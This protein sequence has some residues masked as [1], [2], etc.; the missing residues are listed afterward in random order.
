MDTAPPSH[1]DQLM[2]NTGVGPILVNTA[3]EGFVCSKQLIGMGQL[4]SVDARISWQPLGPF[5]NNWN[6][7]KSNVNP[8]MP[9]ARLTI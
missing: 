8:I 1:P 2:I 3:I 6:T 5:T 7:N 4:Q 9:L